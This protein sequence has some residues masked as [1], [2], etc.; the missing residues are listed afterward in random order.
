MTGYPPRV[1]GDYALLADGERG[2]LIGPDGEVAWLCA[3]RWDSDPVF[4]GLIGG[5]GVH[6]VTPVGRFV[7]GGY[8]EDGSLIRRSR[9]VTE[10]GAVEC[11]EALALPAE[12]HR[13]VLL[14]RVTVQYAPARLRLLLAAGSGFA[15]TG[16]HR[17]RRTEDGGW[18]IRAGRLRLRWSGPG[19][20]RA[21]PVGDTL[22]AEVVLGPGETL[23]LALEVSDRRLDGPPPRIADRWRATERAWRE[24]VPPLDG[25]ADAREAR[26]SYAVLLGLTSPRTGGMVAA[27]T[28]SLPERAET[29]RNYDYRYV[30]IRDQCLAGQAVAAFGPYPLLDQAVRFTTA[31]VLEDG[32]RLSPA[33]TVTGGPVPELRPVDLPGYP[34]G[35]DR[36]GNR[37]ARQFQL[38]A[39]GEALLLFAA[40]ARHA[41][42]DLDG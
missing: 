11:R 16:S 17:P 1:L 19:A 42:L 7:P 21:R 8:Y 31:R 30:W 5:T 38:D 14:R 41:R 28:T 18:R 34:G 2:A 27:A 3:P 23:D 22:R 33:Y 26:F 12:P 13:A 15:A 37:V 35:H 40:A 9:W 4:A 24:A 29:G 10:D 39:F 6:A 25:T 36:V 32:P 20:E